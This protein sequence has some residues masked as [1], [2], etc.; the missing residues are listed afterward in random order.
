MKVILKEDVEKL[1][2]SGDTVEVARGYARNYLL[3]RGF[4]LEAT[5]GN[6]KLLEGARRREARM[7]KTEMEDAIELAASLS[8]ASCT[9][10]VL[11]GKDD[12]MFGSV[13]AADIAQVLTEKGFDVDKRRIRIKKPIKELGIYRVPIRLH[14]EVETQVKVWVVK[15]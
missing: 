15:K 2:K 9:V 5:P 10:P 1:G 3:P 11:V 6:I 7:L 8:K 12:K 14:Q 13:T 4:A